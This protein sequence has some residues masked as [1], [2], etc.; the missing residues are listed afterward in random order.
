MTS[1]GE[2]SA[3]VRGG[4]CSARELVEIALGEDPCRAFTWRDPRATLH[5]EAIDRAVARGEDPG[6]LAG[7]PIALKANL[8]VRDWPCDCGSQALSGWTAPYDATVASRLRAAGAILIGLCNMDEFGMGSSTERSI[9]GPTRNP[10]DPER[11]AGGSSGG[12]AAAVA[13]GLVP[14]ALGS[15]TGGS[16]RQPAALC[17][18]FGFKPSYGRISRRGLVAYASSLD[19]VGVLARSADDLALAVRKAREMVGG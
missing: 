15:D 5:A 9:H 12:S 3:R 16:V 1:A 14:I 11:V 13:A 17:G 6:P 18:V 4:E 19:H 8:C 7:I 10:A 2:L